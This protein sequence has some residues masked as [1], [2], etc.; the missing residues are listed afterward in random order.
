VECTPAN[1]GWVKGAIEQSEGAGFEK[2]IS[3]P[4]RRKLSS[5][6][7]DFHVGDALNGFVVSPRVAVELARWSR[8]RRS[9]WRPGL[10]ARARRR[11]SHSDVAPGP[12][13]DGL[14]PGTF[15]RKS[16][17]ERG[18]ADRVGFRPS[19]S[20][21]GCWQSPVVGSSCPRLITPTAA[22]GGRLNLAT[23]RTIQYR[24]PPPLGGLEAAIPGGGVR[25]I[26]RASGLPVGPAAAPRPSPLGCGPRARR[27]GGGRTWG[28]G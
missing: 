13:S 26:A 28:L 22:S 27:S 18:W 6:R 24:F 10:V 2:L 23:S 1:R 15:M 4:R 14:S 12:P 20:A 9:S 16:L 5:C 3:Y 19:Q 21:L 11:L 8:W 25:A 7:W 17:P